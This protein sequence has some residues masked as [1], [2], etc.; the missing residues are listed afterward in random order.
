MTHYYRNT[1]YL[2]SRAHIYRETFPGGTC[3]TSHFLLQ[4][5]TQLWHEPAQGLF[6]FAPQRPLRRSR[7]WS[8][9]CASGK[10][11]QKPRRGRAGWCGRLTRQHHLLRF[12]KEQASSL[13]SLASL[14]QGRCYNQLLS[15]P[16]AAPLS[17]RTPKPDDWV[18]CS[19]SALLWAL[20][21]RVQ[22][23]PLGTE[24]TVCLMPSISGYKLR[25]RQQ[26]HARQRSNTMIGVI[27]QNYSAL[28][29]EVVSVHPVTQRKMLSSGRQ[30]EVTYLAF[31]VKEFFL[32]S[33][34]GNR[35]T[36]KH[37]SAL[38]WW[39]YLMHWKYCT[40]YCLFACCSSEDW[41]I[42]RPKYILLQKG[43]KETDVQKKKRGHNC[44]QHNAMHIKTWINLSRNLP[45]FQHKPLSSEWPQLWKLSRVVRGTKP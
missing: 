4:V 28:E 2:C 8:R 43:I 18:S 42:C 7:S 27:Y 30:N 21:R 45:Y 12:P 36:T 44:I 33:V 13:R 5:N 29:T 15:L 25:S 6:P 22:R 24:T 1:R 39:C 3:Y 40:K 26:R 17:L 9:S 34:T 20:L 37:S 32:W 14:T 41:L 23:S 16:A 38:W 31:E 11:H 19:R 10:L 35:W